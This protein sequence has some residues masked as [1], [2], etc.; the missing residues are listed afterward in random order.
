ITGSS[1]IHTY[2]IESPFDSE[3]DLGF[4]AVSPSSVMWDAT[5]SKRDMSDCEGIE[6]RRWVSR[7]KAARLLPGREKEIMSLPADAMNDG[8]FPLQYS[9][10]T[11][12]TADMIPY[13]EFFYLTTR[14]AIIV[15]DAGTSRA[16]E[17]D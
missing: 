12:L 5:F 8:K 1:L 16:M 17:W 2:P 10:M 6:R 4:S 11:N 13:D 15:M 3:I 7:R 9:L 14:K